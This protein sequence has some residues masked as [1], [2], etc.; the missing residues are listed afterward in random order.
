MERSAA[1]TA[2]QPTQNLERAV[3]RM[4]AQLEAQGQQ[5]AAL[6]AMVKESQA[7]ASAGRSRLYDK[8]DD[9]SDRIG[10]TEEVVKRIE[11][12][13]TDFGQLRERSRGFV[14]A[15]ILAW[16]VF[17]GLL[18]WAGSQAWDWF[19]NKVG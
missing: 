15:V 6:T 14:F 2:R 5:I 13:A 3:G 17:G 1:M 19:I 7:E 9:L 16:A 18:V 10:K 12:L 11:P 4:E 8:V